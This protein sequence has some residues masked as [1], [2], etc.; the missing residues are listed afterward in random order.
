MSVTLGDLRSDRPEDDILIR[1]V[2]IV[3]YRI[4]AKEISGIGM[5][6][7]MTLAENSKRTRDC[8][9]N[10]AYGAQRGISIGLFNSAAE[11]FGIQIGILNYAKNN[12]KFLQLLP[13]INLHL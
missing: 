1:G 13:L 3:G 10:R 5:S 6:V 2:N 4:R 8:A 9:Y 12:P 11:L 7:A